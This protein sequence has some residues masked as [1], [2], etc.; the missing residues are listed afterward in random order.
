MVEFACYVCYNMLYYN[1]LL[2]WDL[3][4]LWNWF[5]IDCLLWWNIKAGLFTPL[6]VLLPRKRTI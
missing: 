3:G 4:S 1:C 5:G 6:L 2:G